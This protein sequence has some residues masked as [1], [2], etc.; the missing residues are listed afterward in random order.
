MPPLRPELLPE[1]GEQVVGSVSHLV[2]AALQT[3]GLYL[4][5]DILGPLGGI[6]TKFGLL[7][8]VVALVASIGGYI[9]GISAPRISLLLVGTSLFF[10]MLRTTVTVSPTG[11]RVG[12]R[13]SQEAPGEQIALLKEVGSANFYGRPATVSWFFAKADRLVSEVIQKVNAFLLNAQFKEDLLVVAREQTLAKLFSSTIQEPEFLSLLSVGV[14]GE[15]GERTQRQQEKARLEAQLAREKQTFRPRATETQARLTQTNLRL[16]E[17]SDYRF[18]A[19]AGVIPYLIHRGITAEV[20]ATI[21][22]DDVYDWTWKLALQEAEVLLDEVKNKQGEIPWS[23]VDRDIRN[24][25]YNGRPDLAPRV[26]AAY[27]FKQSMAQGS[28]A[29]LM[30]TLLEHSPMT[31]RDYN[32]RYG[33][34]S[35]M[36][37]QGMLMV[38]MFFSSMIP[39]V[40]GLLLFFL[41]GAFPFFC[42]FL[43]V[44]DHMRSFLLWFSLWIWVKSWDV[45]FA[46]LVSVKHLLW[47]FLGRKSLKLAEGNSMS[48]IQSAMRVVENFDPLANIGVYY[49]LVSALTLAIPII[50]AQFCVGASDLLG[51]FGNAIDQTANKM[52]GRTSWAA[53]RPYASNLEQERKR[54]QQTNARAAAQKWLQSDQ[55]KEYAKSGDGLLARGYQAA[56][57]MEMSRGNYSKDVIGAAADL[58][59]FSK[60]PVS[61][62][63]S[64]DISGGAISAL[65]NDKNREFVS[66]PAGMNINS[67]T[68]VNASDKPADYSTE[69][70]E[71]GGKVTAIAPD[72]ATGGE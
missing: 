69:L 35:I 9:L 7:F 16:Q 49:A 55:A 62:S 27:I 52:Y 22:C 20:P 68:A 46:L 42:F 53:R 8:F 4:Q 17:L 38:M 61:M 2:S 30:G 44:P 59:Y 36:D 25:L 57:Q 29:N 1:S 31:K 37:G 65:L 64:A 41:A 43:L 47:E 28:H 70:L 19:P 23:A 15:C 56:Y 13:V 6:L 10:L 12:D 32:I 21:S 5:G 40:Q 18:E 63:N 34:L 48:D 11:V 66:P 60:R 51:A 50:A 24:L 26:L 14:M 39:Y 71:I 3:G 67:G 54:L 58:A 45:G 72:G 33:M